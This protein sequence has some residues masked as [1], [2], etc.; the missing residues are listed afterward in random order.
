MCGDVVVTFRVDG[1][2]R[3]VAMFI[4]TYESFSR[5]KFC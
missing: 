5:T 3:K 1:L 2:H 4:N